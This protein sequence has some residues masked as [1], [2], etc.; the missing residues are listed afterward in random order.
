LKKI[1]AFVISVLLV[2]VV[3]AVT[4]IKLAE[5]NGI[6]HDNAHSKVLSV[7]NYGSYI[8]PDLL[9]KFTNE[10]GYQV[11]YETYDSNESMMVKLEQGGSNY[12]LVFPSEPFVSKLAMKNLLEPLDYSKI[13]GIKN[14]DPLLLNKRFDPHNKYS[15]PYFW[16][17]TGI[18]FNSKVYSETDVNMWSKLWDKKFKN[19]IMLID[20]PRESIGMALQSIGYSE[21]DSVT[22]HILQAKEQLAKLAPNVKAILN[23]EIRTYVVSG[24]SNVAIAYSGI[25]DYAHSENKNIQY[26]VPNR[27]GSIWTDNISI[28]KKA[29]NKRAAYAFINFLLRPEN[30]AKNAQY[31][32]YSSPNLAAKKYLPKS[33]TSDPILY[34]K[35]ST[36]EKLEHYQVLSDKTTE[37]YSNAWLEAKLAIAN[38]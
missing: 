11:S 26:V 18:M 23:D 32:A 28:P 10:T 3:L 38:K 35:R 6:P 13:K 2:C 31:V 17:T 7:Y 14:L 30:A 25:A 5:N 9:D 29:E 27:G 34:P 15:L 4:K 8:D 24:E 1:V 37:A 16:G 36:I 21:N 12:D 22:R 33:V 19:Q 20:A